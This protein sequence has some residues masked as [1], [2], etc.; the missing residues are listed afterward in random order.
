[1]ILDEQVIEGAITSFNITTNEQ[2]AV[3]PLASL[4]VKVTVCAVL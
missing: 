4:A 1:M 3:L 2:D